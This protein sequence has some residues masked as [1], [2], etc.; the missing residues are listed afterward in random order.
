M[1]A[2]IALVMMLVVM[3][4]DAM[5]PVVMCL[6]VVN[7]I[8]AIMTTIAIMMIIAIVMIVVMMAVVT[9]V[10]IIQTSATSIAVLRFVLSVAFAQIIVFC[11]A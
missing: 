10:A 1:L 11:G 2:I 9:I 6:L 4:T 3:I 5:V 7:A 8:V